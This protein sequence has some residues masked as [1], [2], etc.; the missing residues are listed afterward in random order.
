MY[1]LLY[2][3]QTP[4]EI[5]RDRRVLL[6]LSR[7]C[8]CAQPPPAVCPLACTAVDQ[9]CEYIL[10]C[11]GVC[12]GSNVTN[13]DQ[14]HGSAGGSGSDSEGDIDGSVLTAMIL[15]VIFSILVTILP[16]VYLKDNKP[17]VGFGF[18]VA[19]LGKQLEKRAWLFPIS[20]VHYE[21]CSAGQRQ[22][23]LKDSSF[24]RDGGHCALPCGRFCLAGV[25]LRVRD[26]SHFFS[27]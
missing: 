3:D 21:D 2:Q 19:T 24:L 12:G 27:N 17:G 4:S 18:A 15:Q 23:K 16:A 22:G 14:P 7:C 5:K 11:P 9:R 10:S 6:T 26:A 1:R 20:L 13:A 25:G 8:P